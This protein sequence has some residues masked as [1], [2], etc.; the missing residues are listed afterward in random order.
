MGAIRAKRDQE[1]KDRPREQREQRDTSRDHG[2]KWR[3]QEK[4]R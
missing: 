4:Q 2:S 3:D 1:S